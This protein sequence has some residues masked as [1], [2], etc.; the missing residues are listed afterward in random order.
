MII[1]GDSLS[2]THNLAEITNGSSQIFQDLDCPY[3][4]IIRPQLGE[5]PPNNIYQKK[6]FSDGYNWT[7]YF[8]KT[9][10]IEL[11]KNY[12]VGGASIHNYQIE[13]KIDTLEM[14]GQY[15]VSKSMF[16]QWERFIEDLENKYVE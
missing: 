14:Q 13:K 9:Y 1:F 16:E 2:D 15:G 5:M 8:T 7:D 11:I 6:R 12:S 10:N 4:N 3:K